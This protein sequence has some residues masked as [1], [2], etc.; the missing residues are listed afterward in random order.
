ATALNT[1]QI[2]LAWTDNTA[3]ETGFTIE[4]CTGAGCDFSVKDTFTVGA[5]V[6]AYSDTSVC[7]STTYSYRVKAVNST[8]PWDSGYSNTV[9]ATTP[10]PAAPGAL[11]ATAVTDTQVDLSWTDNTTDETGFKIERCAGDGCADFL[12]IGTTASNISTY[13]DLTALPSTTYCYRVRAYKTATC[14]W[15]TGYSLTACDLS[16]SA[17]PINLTAT[18][19]NSMKIRIDWADTSNDEDGFE[20]EVQ[21]WNGRFVKI[22]TVGPNVSTYTDTIGI[23]PQK[24]YIY[25]VRAYR[26]SDKSPYSNEAS[27]TTPAYTQGDSTCQ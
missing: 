4:R 10:T 19:L 13:S 5:N 18:A 24:Q 20:I 27:A 9:P 22:A 11:S 14:N 23:E 17:H 8:V 1:T 25:R 3:S 6:I 26:S 15:D 16:I 21:I 12:Q 2:N 7:N